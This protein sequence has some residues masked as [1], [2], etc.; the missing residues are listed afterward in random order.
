MT[1]TE[2]FAST[3]VAAAA[4]AELQLSDRRVYIVDGVANVRGK[5][6]K[7]ARK[8]LGNGRD[9]RTAAHRSRRAGFVGEKKLTHIPIS[10][11]VESKQ[12][13][14]PCLRFRTGHVVHG[15]IDEIPFPPVR[16]RP[17]R[18][19]RPTLLYARVP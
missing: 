16:V 6:W 3:T 15:V 1:L 18:T 8:P 2:N 13:R 10:A 14:R 19:G 5:T 12:R 4:A 11:V 7:I 9:G 17:S